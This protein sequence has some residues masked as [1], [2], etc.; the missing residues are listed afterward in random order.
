MAKYVNKASGMLKHKKMSQLP[1][2]L[3][4]DSG[5]LTTL[6]QLQSFWHH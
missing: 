2:E 4:V 6:H 1:T 3:L 5:Y